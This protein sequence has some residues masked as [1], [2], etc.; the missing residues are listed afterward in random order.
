MKA[1]EQSDQKN[2]TQEKID[3]DHIVP[4]IHILQP[5]MTPDLSPIQ[6]THAHSQAYNVEISK[7]STIDSFSSTSYHP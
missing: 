5:N 7:D 4:H 6:W 2:Q 1:V 3:S